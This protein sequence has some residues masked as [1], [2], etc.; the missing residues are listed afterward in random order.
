[1]GNQLIRKIINQSHLP[2][3]GLCM[4]FYLRGLDFYFDVMKLSLLI[5]QKAS[6]L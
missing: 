2:L 1:M 4:W 3:L 5:T 6:S